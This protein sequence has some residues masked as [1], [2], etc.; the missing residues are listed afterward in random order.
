MRTI[1]SY[2]HKLLIPL[3]VLIPLL[4]LSA[5]MREVAD[6]LPLIPHRTLL[7]YLTG[8]NSQA[9]EIQEK[10]DAL[11]ATAD[12]VPGTSHLLVFQDR[13]GENVPRLLEIK[14]GGAETGKAENK[15]GQ[16]GYI[17]VLEEYKEEQ[18]SPYQL[19]SQVLNDM[20]RLYPGGD[21]GLLLFSHTTGWLPAGSDVRPFSILTD[22]G[23]PFELADFARAI[24]DGQF[25]FI[26]FESGLM[27]GAEV[28]YE[29]RDKADYL[30]ASSAEIP[31]PGFMPVYGKM[32]QR[33]FLNVPDLSGFAGDYYQYRNTLPDKDRSA[34]IS[35]V[36]TSAL[37]PLKDLLARAE[38]SVT[39]W[40]WVNRSGIQH[41]DLRKEKYLFYDLEGYIRTIGTQPQIDELARLL[42]GA[43]A[44]KAATP[45]FMPQAQYG[46]DILQH[47]GLTI[48]I[49]V[50][51]Y[52]YLNERRT[53]LS[54]FADY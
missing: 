2:I 5:C 24:P 22:G 33:L 1:Q 34:T 41:F 9:E 52:Y 21:Y 31:S 15:E 6:N 49:P 11:V 26:L 46:Y 54:L 10:I 3:A 35:L 48:Y 42:D 38:S 40:E 20:V 53:K 51:G 4:L 45:A 7:I 23:N 50:P 19:F 36:R 18:V 30:L 16:K 44:Y 8:G 12:E 37:A 47:C 32:L 28:V 27:A 17:E 13:V 43:I 29:L 14:S 39:Y 25:R